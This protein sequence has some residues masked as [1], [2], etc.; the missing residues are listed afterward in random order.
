MKKTIVHKLARFKPGVQKGWLHA[1]AGLVWLGVGVMLAGIAR[2]WLDLVDTST[3]LLLLLGGMTL[4]AGIYG[5]GFSRLA[6]KN[7]RRIEALPGERA[8]VFA[9]QEW[10]S[11][12]LVAFMVALGIYLRVYSPIPRPLLALLYLGIGGGLF[13]AGSLYFVHLAR[14]RQ[15][16]A[17]TAQVSEEAAE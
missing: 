9:F 8:C 12:P 3:A 15:T 2:Q 17:E 11:Y 6:R 5:L 10:K 4:A 1:A 16:D 13:F 14:A 7:I